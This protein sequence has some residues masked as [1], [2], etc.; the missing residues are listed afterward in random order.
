M[1]P[2]E[3]SKR[4]S[5]ILDKLASIAKGDKRNLVPKV[6]IELLVQLKEILDRLRRL[7]I[8]FK[9]DFNSVFPIFNL[10]RFR[11]TL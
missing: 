3:F 9:R 5:E 7:P 2:M 8:I 11:Q 4:L 1:S 6:K 10:L